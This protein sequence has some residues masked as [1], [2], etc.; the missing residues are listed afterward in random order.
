MSWKKMKTRTIV[1][2]TICGTEILFESKKWMFH[3]GKPVCVKCY[4]QK[5]EEE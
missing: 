1:T 3:E 4:A 2:C 5:I